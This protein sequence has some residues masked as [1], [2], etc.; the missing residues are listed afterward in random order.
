MFISSATAVQEPNWSPVTD[1]HTV[2]DTPHATVTTATCRRHAPR[3][4]ILGSPLRAAC[5]G[6]WS[7]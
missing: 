4:S 5:R 2:S 3:P 7:Q 1:R 6:V